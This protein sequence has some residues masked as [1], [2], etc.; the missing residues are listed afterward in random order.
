MVHK[1][2]I[3]LGY[4][5]PFRIKYIFSCNIKTLHNHHEACFILLNPWI[6]RKPI[7][8]AGNEVNGEFL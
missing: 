4:F 2:K 1:T 6:P 5:L 7:L 3:K 8:M